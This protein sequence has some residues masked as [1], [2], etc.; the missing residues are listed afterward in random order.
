MSPPNRRRSPFF[1]SA[2]DRGVDV[3]DDQIAALLPRSASAKRVG[4]HVA[5]A[6]VL[7]VGDRAVEV[8][9]ALDQLPLGAV[10]IEPP[11]HGSPAGANG[12]VALTGGGPALSEIALSSKSSNQSERSESGD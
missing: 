12:S 11:Q 2:V 6:S 3:G 9:V 8:G 10:A 5:G 1:S 4:Q 7:G